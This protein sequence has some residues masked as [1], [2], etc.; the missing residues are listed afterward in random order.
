M[1]QPSGLS[2]AALKRP[3]IGHRKKLK[4]QRFWRGISILIAAVMLV[5][6]PAEAIAAPKNPGDK[7]ISDAQS[8]KDKKAAEVGRLN[9]LL[10]RKQGDISRL[11]AAAELAS[12]RYNKARVDQETAEKA[13][14]KARTSVT[15][16]Q[17]QLTQSRAEVS[18]VARNTYMRGGFVGSAGALLEQ[19]GPSKFLTRLDYLRYMSHQRLTAISDFQRS[20]VQK[21]NAESAARKAAQDAKTAATR[22]AEAKTQATRRVSEARKQIGLVQKQITDVQAKLQQAEIAL[23]GLVAQR[24]KYQQWQQEQARQRAK[25]QAE[26][27]ARAADAKRNPPIISGGLLTGGWSAAKGRA[28]VNAAMKWLGTPYAWAGGTRGGPSYGSVPDEGVLGFDCSGLTLWAWGQVGVNLP[29]YSGYQYREG[30]HVSRSNLLP[31]D[32]VFWSNN[33]DESG[34]H[35]VALYIGGNRVLQAPQSG[36]VVRISRMWSNEYFGA[37]RPGTAG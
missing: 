23:N 31:G 26:A 21:A 7:Q 17:K 5:G 9:A 12:E 11:N 19:G 14:A 22:A 28:A 33:G 1:L 10:A 8:T 6:L 16:A 36:D 15:Q 3:G 29:H 27:R 4:L 18:K 25:E 35:H 32:L 34:I 20:T 13:A 2:T 24:K 37:T 30:T